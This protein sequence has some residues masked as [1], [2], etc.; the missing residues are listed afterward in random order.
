MPH[1]DQTEDRAPLRAQQSFFL[2]PSETT[3][4]LKIPLTPSRDLEL[5]GFQRLAYLVPT[6]SMCENAFQTQGP[7][8]RPQGEDRALLPVDII[9]LRE[10]WVAKTLKN[11]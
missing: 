7:A 11:V 4:S 8:P 3:E 10:T 2:G 9:K 5:S 6:Q 1:P